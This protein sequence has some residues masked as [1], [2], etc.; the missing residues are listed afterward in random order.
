VGILAGT[1][2]A[3]R[4]LPD[5]RPRERSRFLFFAGLS[6]LV[7]LAQTLGFVGSEALFLAR[8]GAE[9]LP[10]TFVAASLTTVVGS[11]LYGSLVGRQR[12][13]SLFAQ[14]LLGSGLLLLPASAAAAAGTPWL[15]PLPFC[16]LYLTQAVFLNHF[17]TFASDYFDTQGCKRLFPLFTVGAS[18]GGALGGGLAMLAARVAGPASLLAGWGIALVAAALW[19]RLGRRRLRRWGPLEQ[20]ELDET[21]VEGMRSAL[22]YLAGSPLGRW[23][24]LGALGMVLALFVAQY[25]YS[26][27]FAQSFPGEAELAAFLGVYLLATNAVEIAIEIALTPRLIRRFGVPSANLIHPLLTLASFAGLAARPGLAMAVLARAN[28]EL[29]ENALAGPVRSLV[30]NALPLRLRGRCRAFLEGIV[31]YGGMSLAGLLLLLLGQPDPIWLCVAGG[32]AALLYICANLKARRE[33]LRA[34]LEAI[35]AG[36]LDLDDVGPE[37]GRFEAAR[38]ADAWEQL[39]EQEGGRPSRPL[40]E[41]IPRLAERGVVQPL[42]R[43][44]LHPS[45]VVRCACL[46]ALARSTAGDFSTSL[47]SALG[48]P[49]PSVRLAALRALRELPEAARSRAL[50]ARDLAADPDP[51]VRAEA[52]ALA[53]AAGTAQLEE[54]IRSPLATEAMAALAVAPAA[55]AEAALARLA[56]G[57]PALRAAVLAF[58]ARE[59]PDAPLP[60]QRLE[61]ALADPEPRVRAAAVALLARHSSKAGLAALTDALFDP[62]REVQDAA[63]LALSARGAEGVLAAGPALRSD[64]E[65]SVDAALRVV[66]AAA[67]PRARAILYAE[68]RSR[69]RALWGS[70]VSRER[71]PEDA[72]LGSRFLRAALADDAERNRRLAFRILEQ[73]EAERVI[74]RVERALRFGATRT[75]GD[76]LE[77]LSNLGDPEAAQLLALLHDAAPFEDR[78]AEALRSLRLPS[79]AD[80]I[81][82]AARRSEVR[83]IRLGAAAVAP[84]SGLTPEEEDVM[85]RLLALKRVPLFA[86]LS[87]EQLDAVERLAKEA[88]YL[89]G[90]LIVRE[91][92][93]G[94]EL[95]LLLEGEV[96]VIKA[97][98]EPGETLL[99]TLVAV[100]YFGEMAILDANPRSASVVAASPARL[101]SLHGRSLEELILQR[102]EISFEILRVLTARVRAAEGRL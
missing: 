96:R 29:L 14:M 61:A 62:A 9:R 53:G 59:A 50:L 27:V 100:S 52:A 19:L 38:L 70:L 2:L 35:R 49:E 22:R 28:R 18:V 39:L 40:L 36:R 101:L 92:D 37:L 23:L 3:W 15:V 94:N 71:L 11:L 31:V 83:W 20:D 12:N 4:I 55:L 25:L 32:A 44:S 90:E 43:A 48:D 81:V 78:V 91:G 68:L 75:R 99:S 34:L 74:S 80:E 102:P 56:G 33:Y 66:T 84:G 1:E 98:G 63:A 65:R 85:E 30:Y 58:L 47:A 24:A 42:L 51:C 57:E 64:R 69:V 10:A 5:V 93:P 54:M 87:L 41:L 82:E 16:F 79:G 8:L 76:A 77:V 6:M 89:P 60:P 45:A 46:S 67:G 72:R 7:G 97:F 17:W 21:S 13:D 86:Q 88:S 73:I 95:F 26:Q